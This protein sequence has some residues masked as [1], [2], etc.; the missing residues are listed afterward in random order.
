[1]GNAIRESVVLDQDLVVVTDREEA[2]VE[3]PVDRPGER[4]AVPDR[5][6][7]VVLD[8]LDVRRLDLWAAA[9]VADAETGECARVAVGAS[10]RVAERLVT[11]RST[12]EL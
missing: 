2:S 7:T 10:N 5:V 12:D 4:D 9:A 1:M 6:R 3:H 11:E 8:R